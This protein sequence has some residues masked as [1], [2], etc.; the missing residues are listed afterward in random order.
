[1]LLHEL[2]GIGRDPDGGVTRFAW[3][4][5]DAELREWFSARARAAG[6][7]VEVDGNGNLWAWAGGDLPGRAFVVGSHLD[8]VASGGEWDGPLGVAGALAAVEQLRASGWQPQQPFALAVFADEEGGRFGVACLGSRLLTGAMTPDRALSLRDDDGTT[9][10]EAMTSAGFDPARVGADPRRLAGIRAFVELHV[11]QGRMLLPGGARGLAGAG[12]PLGVASEIWPHGRWRLDLTGRA[13][14]AGT[15]ALADRDDPVLSLAR[16]I[17]AVRETAEELDVLATVGRVRVHPG[18]VNAIA[19]RA[20]LWIDARGAEPERV[21]ALVARIE[22]R[23]AAAAVEESWTAVTRFDRALTADVSA[24]IDGDV[25]VLPSG[26]GH[27]AGVLALAGVPTAMMFVRN[28]T[29][30]SHAPDERAEESDAA[31]GV[32]ALAEL[33]RRQT[34]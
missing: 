16:A 7:D 33:I 24:V 22:E 17:V 13:D 9:L 12:A 15:T 1:M 21:R 29:G 5:D 8:S 14:H 3:T 30:V 27:D 19:S 23:S 20:S 6:L 18:A 31:A 10:A 32:R 2:A 26:A 4:R 28:P 25:P 34:A 11:E